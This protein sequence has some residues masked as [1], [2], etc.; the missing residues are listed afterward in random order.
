MAGFDVGEQVLQP[1]PFQL[2][3]GEPTIVIAGPR[4]DPALVLLAADVGLTSIALRRERIEFLLEPFLRD[5]RV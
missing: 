3:T 1:G 2:A 5:L 4:Q